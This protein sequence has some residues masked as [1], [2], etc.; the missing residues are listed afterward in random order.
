MVKNYITAESLENVI[1]SHDYRSSE[2]IFN[3]DITNAS[4][5][6]HSAL[7]YA[8]ILRM[9]EREHG[10]ISRKDYTLFKENVEALATKMKRFLNPRIREYVESFNDLNESMRS[11]SVYDNVYPFSSLKLEEAK[12]AFELATSQFVFD[13]DYKKAVKVY[14]VIGRYKDVLIE[15]K[16][17]HGAVSSLWVMDYLRSV[18]PIR[19]RIAALPAH[20]SGDSLRDQLTTQIALNQNQVRKLLYQ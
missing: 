8:K 12:M 18:S 17:K 9:M 1:A 13:P 6:Y 11:I 15:I 3:P 4:D 16:E 14:G 19:Q 7:Q 10:G 2:W 5:A 20:P